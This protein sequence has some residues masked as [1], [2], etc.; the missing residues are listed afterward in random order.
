MNDW[1]SIYKIYRIKLKD[2]PEARK[3]TLGLMEKEGMKPTEAQDLL[4]KLI[5][6]KMI[7]ENREAEHIPTLLTPSHGTSTI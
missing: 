5:Y 4:T 7:A 6:D 2:A 1:L 3:I